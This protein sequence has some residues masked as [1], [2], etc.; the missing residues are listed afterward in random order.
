MELETYLESAKELLRQNNGRVTA[1]RVM[2]L[3]VIFEAEKPLTATEIENALNKKLTKNVDRATVF[4][5]LNAFAE[6]KLIHRLEENASYIACKHFACSH[7][8]HVVL[9]CTRCDCY[10]E[11]EMPERIFRESELFCAREYNFRLNDTHVQL[12]GLCRNC[13]TK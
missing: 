8:Y 6:L 7:A 4:R 5:M 1:P 12:G 10:Q 2:T 11:V 13:H 9:R 3:Q